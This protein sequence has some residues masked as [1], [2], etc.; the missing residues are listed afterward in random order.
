VDK[1]RVTTALAKYA[2]NP[3][4]R[5]LAG[6][7]PWWALLETIGRKTGEP[8]RT[9][10]GN[11]L[12]GDTFWIV[13]EHGWAAKYVRNIQA[14]PRVRVRVNK[15]WR[16]GLAHPLAE[17]DA[18]ARQRR[19]RPFNAAVVRLMGTELL[20][21][22]IDLDKIVEERINGPSTTREILENGV[23]AGVIAGAVSGAPSTLDALVRHLD[24]LEAT[25]AAGS[26]LLPDEH[27]RQ[28]LL[29]AGLFVHGI[30]SSG[31][32]I[33]LAAALP[34]KRTALWGALA[35]S[36]IAAFDL[37]LVGRGNP[38]IRS[39][40]IA[41]Q[42]ADHLAFGVIVGLGLARRRARPARGNGVSAG[43]EP[44]RP[45]RH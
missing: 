44:D 45:W 19:L 4:V 40:P 32:G 1:R 23:A 34:P 39:L 16:A 13:A 33:A 6:Y 8:R 28:R 43:H 18:T 42:V 11:G 5:R 7:V 38:R 27:R 17:D 20:T 14:D 41:P 3:I 30:L 29:L 21:V 22:R 35:G 36:L 26:L 24:P 10:V 25:A 37:G 31:W 12:E 15:C 2:I 9:P